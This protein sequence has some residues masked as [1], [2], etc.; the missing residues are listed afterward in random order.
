M[1]FVRLGT[2]LSLLAAAVVAATFRFSLRYLDGEA[3]RG[4]FLRYLAF[5]GV[6]AYVLVLSS[7]LL[8]LSAAWSPTS[9]GLHRLLSFYP[10][11]AEVRRSARKKLLISHL[12]ALAL[13]AAIALIW[14]TWS[15]LDA[16]AFLSTAIGPE[17]PDAS[18][19]V[20]LLIVLAA[21]TKSA[22]FRFH[23]WLPE[24]NASDRIG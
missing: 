9:L 19:A 10:D 16:N 11:R 23:S 12:V 3:G 18:L 14:R 20:G 6:A 2:A 8:L 24:T 17:N 4:R 22:Q 5:T 15:R 7:H 1:T 21:L 13:I